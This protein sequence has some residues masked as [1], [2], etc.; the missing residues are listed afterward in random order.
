MTSRTSNKVKLFNS[1]SDFE[2]LNMKPIL[3]KR[4]NNEEYKLNKQNQ[5]NLKKIDKLRIYTRNVKNLENFK[6]LLSNSRKNFFKPSKKKFTP[7]FEF[8]KLETKIIHQKPKLKS[9]LKTVTNGGFLPQRNSDNLF[10]T[11]FLAGNMK[12]NYPDA[13]SLIKEE[14]PLS[15]NAE[16]IGKLKE[17]LKPKGN[18]AM[19]APV[20]DTLNKIYK[21]DDDLAAKLKEV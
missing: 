4:F 14:S 16:E 6:T 9:L 3:V 10:L 12:D 5:E 18:R 19:L 1:N 11:D 8:R 13:I 15:E 2:R 17:E 21:T 7:N 20:N